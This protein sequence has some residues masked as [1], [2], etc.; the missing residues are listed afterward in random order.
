MIV[1]DSFEFSI[2][3]GYFTTQK[4]NIKMEKNE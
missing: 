3:R 4:I 1:S 2:P